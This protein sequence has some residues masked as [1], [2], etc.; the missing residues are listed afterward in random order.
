MAIENRS[1]SSATPFAQIRLENKWNENSVAVLRRFDVTKYLLYS[2]HSFAAGSVLSMV[3]PLKIGTTRLGDMGMGEASW[4]VRLQKQASQLL[5][6]LTFVAALSML[7]GTVSAEEEENQFQW[8][9]TFCRLQTTYCDTN[10]CMQA[11]TLQCYNETPACQDGDPNTPNG[12]YMAEFVAPF[13]FGDDLYTA[14]VKLNCIKDD[15]PLEDVTWFRPVCEFSDTINSGSGLCPDFSAEEQYAILASEC[16]I[17]TGHP[18]T[19]NK[20]V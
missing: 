18:E 9:T 20:T 15:L 6:A 11:K 4:V 13:K 10:D 14:T 17:H 16:D 12:V 1:S 19:V 7:A 5:G 3:N 8:T 2:C